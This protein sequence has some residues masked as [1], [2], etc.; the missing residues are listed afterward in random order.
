MK[1]RG[2]SMII[3]TVEFEKRLGSLLAVKPAASGA[4]LLCSVKAAIELTVLCSEVVC[5]P[6]VCSITS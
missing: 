1:T 4:L 3:A 6:F 5:C 2:P